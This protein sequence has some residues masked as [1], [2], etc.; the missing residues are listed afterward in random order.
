MFNIS[1]YFTRGLRNTVLAKPGLNFSYKGPWTQIYNG[2]AID[3][4]Y[5]GDF[6]SAEYTITVD[7]DPTNREIL[8]CLVAGSPNDASINVYG[9]S[10]TGEPIVNV[11]ATV[12]GSFVEVVLTPK[13]DSKKGAKAAF[14]A[15]YYE[16]HSRI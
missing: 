14:Q 6:S 11:S 12:N 10:T 2:E 1:N 16:A 3:R 8:K 7:L 5:I 9:R 15:T 4:W 13:D